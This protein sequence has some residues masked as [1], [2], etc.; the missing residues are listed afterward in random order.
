MT[1]AKSTDSIYPP[2]VYFT[3]G[4]LPCDC[5]VVAGSCLFVFGDAK[6]ALETGERV[7]LPSGAF[8]FRSGA[9]GVT[10]SKHW[11]ID[12][13]DLPQTAEPISGD[14][15]SSNSPTTGV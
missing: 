1:I 3:G 8:T 10:L 15:Q 6:Y 7:Q 14:I 12:L 11:R 5:V 2:N 9:D 4:Q 13:P